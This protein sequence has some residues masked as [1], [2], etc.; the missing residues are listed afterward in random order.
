MGSRSRPS[1]LPSLLGGAALA[2][3]SVALVLG[4]GEAALRLFPSLIPPGVYGSGRFDPVLGMHVRGSDVL[5]TRAGVVRKTPNADGFLD[6]PHAETKPAGTFRIGFFGDSYV[7]SN[8][9]PTEATFFR[10]LP[11][12][13]RPR[14]VETLAFGLSGWGTLQ[15]FRAFSVNAR[16]YDLDLAVY[17]FVENDPG[18]N[19]LELSASRHDAEMPY[20]TLADEPPGYRVR[21]GRPPA[22]PPWFRAAKA[23]QERSLLAQVLWVR[24]RLLQQEGFRPRARAEEKAMRERA[25]REP[26]AKP[27]PNDIPTSWSRDERGDVLLLTERILAEWKR[28]ADGARIPLAVLYVPRGNEMLAGALREEDTWLPWLR[29]TCAKLGLPLLDPRAA[30][31]APLDSATPP[32]DDHFTRA[33][34]EA[35][36]RFLAAEL[37]SLLD[38]AADQGRSSTTN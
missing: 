16:R 15:A 7:E 10:L 38:R 20:A 23:V 17:V 12:A 6:V 25:P 3:A 1:R 8:Q 14:E 30:L 2:A 24:L 31:R 9:V 28:T 32:Y 29:A 36:A 5:Y 27:D 22:D 13:L 4:A 21:E 34:H 35:V 33:G 26:G 19:S 11:A 18:D 37:P